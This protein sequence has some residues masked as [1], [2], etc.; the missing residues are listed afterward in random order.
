MS[1][2]L[3]IPS[4]GRLDFL[5]LGALVHRL[6]PGVYPFHKARSCTIHVSGGEFNTAA[7]LSDCFRLRTGVASAMVRAS[8]VVMSASCA[9]PGFWC[10]GR[11][12]ARR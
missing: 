4:Q 6:D 10:D 3:Q 1:T 9:L 8:S 5:A 12:S 7:N 11:S 2:G